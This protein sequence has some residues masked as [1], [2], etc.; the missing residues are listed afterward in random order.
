MYAEQR[1]RS[2]LQSAVTSME[3]YYRSLEMVAT[4][5]MVDDARLPRVAQLT[6]KTNQLNMTTRRYSEQEIA[7][8]AADPDAR[9]YWIN[10]R[11]RFGDNGVVG[12]MIV[13]TEGETWAFDTFLMSCRVIGRTVETAMLATVTEDALAAGATRL[14]GWFLPTRKNA[15]AEAIYADHGFKKTEE[16]DDGS[17]WELDLA[18][19]PVEAPEWIQR[20]RT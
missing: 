9:V 6:Q 4:I 20:D 3:D 13:R 5:G 12:V 17:R 19:S 14:A 7:A 1:Q 8:F 10:V 18:T 2:E 11:D 15:P 16:S